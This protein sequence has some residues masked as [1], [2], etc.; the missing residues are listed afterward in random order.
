MVAWYFKSQSWY[1][2]DLDWKRNYRNYGLWRWCI[3][4]Y[5]LQ[6][7]ST[8][9]S[10]SIYTSIHEEKIDPK[11]IQITLTPFLDKNAASFTKHL[12]DLLLSAQQ[13]VNGIPRE[14]IEQRMAEIGKQEVF[15]FFFLSY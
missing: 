8:W 11:H 5:D 2:E 1:Y 10:N 13:D 9:W 4:W 3:N 15:S 7:V 12:W 14:F 6:Y